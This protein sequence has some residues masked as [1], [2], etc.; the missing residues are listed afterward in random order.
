MAKGRPTGGVRVDS[1]DIDMV[2]LATGTQ[3][4]RP[5]KSSDHLHPAQKERIKKAAEDIVTGKRRG[6]K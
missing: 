3:K 1:S 5:H 4:D 6:K 2:F